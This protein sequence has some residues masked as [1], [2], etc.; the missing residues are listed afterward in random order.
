MITQLGFM[1]SISIICG[2]FGN[3]NGKM[4]CK[5]FNIYN[6]CKISTKRYL[7]LKIEIKILDKLNTSFY[8]KEFSS[9]QLTTIDDFIIRKCN[10]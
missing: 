3:H 7:F 5:Y 10:S 2:Y 1:D 8:V 4:T 6:L 9:H